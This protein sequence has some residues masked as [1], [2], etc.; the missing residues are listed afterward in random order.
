VESQNAIGFFKL[1]KYRDK[2]ICG[3]T[4]YVNSELFTKCHSIRE[5]QQVV[6]Y[7]GRLQAQKGVKNFLDAVNIISMKRNDI[8][9]MIGGSGP[10]YQQ[11]IKESHSNNQMTFTGWI[12]HDD[13]LPAYLNEL[14]LLVL[15]SGSEGLPTIILEAMACGTPVL[16]TAVGCI[17]DIVIEGETGFILADNEPETI[18]EN[19]ER[20]INFAD[21]DYVSENARQLCIS[22]F[23]FDQVVEKYK[24]VI[25]TL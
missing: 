25:K 20:I 24:E 3:F 2:I 12:S 5:R 18:A 9:F 6:G 13:Q 7:I 17:P 1:D 4:Q 11:L 8:K 19:I 22:N 10:L 14:K 15:P 21:L 23:S 16:A